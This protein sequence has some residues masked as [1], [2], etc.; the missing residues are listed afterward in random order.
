MLS[1]N[2]G[3]EEKLTPTSMCFQSTLV[4]NGK[5]IGICTDTGMRCIGEQ[6]VFSPVRTHV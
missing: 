3:G 5:G 6:G 2:T 1:A 4:T